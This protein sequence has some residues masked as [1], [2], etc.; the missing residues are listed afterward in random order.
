LRLQRLRWHR[1]PEAALRIQLSIHFR[2]LPEA[3]QDSRFGFFL[4]EIL[5]NHLANSEYQSDWVG[6][7]TLVFPD[8]DY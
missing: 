1:W 4:R 7:T 3:F 5:Y 8:Y 6:D 2:S